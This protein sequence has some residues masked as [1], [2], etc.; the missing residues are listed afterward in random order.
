MNKKLLLENKKMTYNQCRKIIL[1]Y[2]GE[3]PVKNM[4][5]VGCVFTHLGK[6]RS[7]YLGDLYGNIKEFVGIK[8][9]KNC[10]ARHNVYYGVKT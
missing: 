7:Y 10:M 4:L 3:D 2:Y 1:D 6:N 8:V 5:V 9:G